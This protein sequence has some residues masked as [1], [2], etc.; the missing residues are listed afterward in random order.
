MWMDITSV[1]DCIAE[2]KAVDARRA[3]VRWSELGLKSRSWALFGWMI[4]LIPPR[5][6]HESKLVYRSNHQRY[7]SMIA[8]PLK[9]DH[10]IEAGYPKQYAHMTPAPNISTRP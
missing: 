1:L 5:C 3:A 6:R 2:V 9:H 8:C 10:K 7:V 4:E